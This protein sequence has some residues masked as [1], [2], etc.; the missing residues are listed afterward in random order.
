MLV[1]KL[2]DYEKKKVDKNY[3]TGKFTDFSCVFEIFIRKLSHLTIFNCSSSYKFFHP[4]KSKK[5][6]KK[7]TVAFGKD[8]ACNSLSLCTC[9]SILL[10]IITSGILGKYKC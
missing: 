4:S 10:F 9:M 3:V 2:L 5:R 6:K 1:K 8:F 7:T